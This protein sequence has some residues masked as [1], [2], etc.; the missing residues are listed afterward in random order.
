LRA[1]LLMFHAESEE[2]VRKTYV[3]FGDGFNAR[4]HDGRRA[5]PRDGPGKSENPP[6]VVLRCVLPSVP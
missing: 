6:E 2:K 1:I 4:F 3:R 5:V